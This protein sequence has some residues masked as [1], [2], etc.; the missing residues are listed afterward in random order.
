MLFPFRCLR[1]EKFKVQKCLSRRIRAILMPRTWQKLWQER[2][3]LAVG[4]PV[5][6][7]EMVL[8]LELN[9]ERD[10]TGDV[11]KFHDTYIIHISKFTITWDHALLISNPLSLQRPFGYLLFD[12][13]LFNLYITANRDSTL[14]MTFMLMAF[15]YWGWIKMS[16]GKKGRLLWTCTG[17]VFIC[18]ETKGDSVLYFSQDKHKLAYI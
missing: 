18:V 12:I 14:L 2:G 6:A 3:V 10:K 8:T 5:S 16:V 13:F 11:G 4:I 7:A 9:L 15:T 17:F 1:L